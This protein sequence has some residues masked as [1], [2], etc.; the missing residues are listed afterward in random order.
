MSVS[1]SPHS[2]LT[3]PDAFTWNLLKFLT[4]RMSSGPEKQ[5]SRQLD[6]ALKLAKDRE[7]VISPRDM[8]AVRDRVML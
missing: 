1:D 3:A 8:E 4:D 2:S 5:G 7:N 6:E